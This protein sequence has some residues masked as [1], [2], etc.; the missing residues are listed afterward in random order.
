M[1]IIL[2]NI[3]ELFA[4]RAAGPA[5]FWQQNRKQYLELRRNRSLLWGIIPIA[6]V[7]QFPFNFTGCHHLYLINS[8]HWPN[9]PA[10]FA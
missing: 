5:V 3:D 8:V 10:R 6:V 2:Y 7:W 1:S 4:F 9:A